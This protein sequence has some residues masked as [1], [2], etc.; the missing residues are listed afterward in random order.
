M[1]G[2]DNQ[3]ELDICPFLQFQLC[4]NVQYTRPMRLAILDPH[5][6]KE[7]FLLCFLS[8]H[9]SYNLR[10]RVG[11]LTF[12]RNRQVVFHLILASKQKH[13]VITM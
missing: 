6:P 3:S 8:K 12:Y 1:F 10:C 7:L 2:I 9:I 4:F 11:F 13:G 5:I